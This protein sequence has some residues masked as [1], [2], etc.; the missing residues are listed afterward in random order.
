MHV[1]S[2]SLTL[3]IWGACSNPSRVRLQTPDQW[4]RCGVAAR[5]PRLVYICRVR[6][7]AAE[8][9]L[10]LLISNTL[11]SRAPVAPALTERVSRPLVGNRTLRGSGLSSPWLGPRDGYTYLVRNRVI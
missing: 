3:L 11:Y 2:S 10:E 7:F 6:G 4:G 8:P 1:P 9:A 5:C